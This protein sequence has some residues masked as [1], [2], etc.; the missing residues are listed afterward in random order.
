MI[1][2]TDKAKSLLN[3]GRI[4]ES[5]ALIRKRLIADRNP[6]ALDSLNQI[7]RNYGFLLHY[8]SEGKEDAG[9]DRMLSDIR[10]QLYTIIRAIEYNL[11]IKESPKLYFSQARTIKYSGMNFSNSFSEYIA[12]DSATLLLDSE[13]EEMR[14]AYEEK[15]R[16]LKDLFSIVWTLPIGDT[17]TLRE[18]VDA[19]C[20]PDIAEDFSALMISALTINLLMAYDRHKLMALVDIYLRSNSDTLKARLLTGILLI[21]NQYAQRVENDYE[22]QIR[23]ETMSETTMFA[24][25][26]RDVFFALVKARG[27]LNLSRRIEQE[28]LPEITKIG[29]DLINKLKDKDGNLNISNLEENPEWEKIMN[30]KVE[31]KL[32]K[33][34]D[35]QTSGGDIMIS[36]FAQLN[37]KFHRFNDIDVWFRP[38]SQ[39]EARSINI[40]DRLTEIWSKLAGVAT[41]CDP[42]KFVFAM[43]I[44]RLPESVRE[45]MVTAFEAQQEQMDEEIKSL[46][47]HSS[48][49]EFET[50]S[51]NYARVLFR[52][53]NF[54]RLKKEFPN[55]FEQRIDI[56]NIPFLGKYFDKSEIAGELADFF[57]KQEFYADAIDYIDI[58]SI[59]DILNRPIYLQKIGYC[60]E[61]LGKKS[62]ALK[63]YSE[64]INLGDDSAWTLRKIFKLGKETGEIESAFKAISQLL[65]M[66]TDN[67]QYLK[68]YLNF[69]VDNFEQLRPNLSQ[70]FSRAEYLLADDENIMRL[71]ARYDF[72]RGDY[73][74]AKEYFDAKYVDV[75]MYL[76]GKALTDA[77]KPAESDSKIEDNGNSDKSEISEV[78]DIL[79]NFSNTDNK[80]EEKNM[81]E[82]TLILAAINILTG[83]SYDAIRQIATVR[84]LT[85]SGISVD[86]LAQR[87]RMLINQSLKPKMAVNTLDKDEEKRLENLVNLHIDAAFKLSNN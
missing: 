78:S 83:N 38:F 74:A 3:S 9:R 48:M 40:S 67:S 85:K 68:E 76:A 44:S 57:F 22:M 16:R 25:K 59:I 84:L 49:P 71:K 27:G 87:L 60:L 86:Y 26:V 14:E 47:L 58:Q 4:S 69:G 82:D 54:F 10:E 77:V 43:N 13:S 53:F 1:S 52:F 17:D 55:P 37:G 72:L 34:N 66:E 31:K 7:E 15:N 75:Q 19:I 73:T 63:K 5:I 35:L 28:I 24:D 39:W 42:D 11:E 21:L 79:I 62:E 2:L 29:P 33:L 20:N 46:M 32:R 23:I 51:W 36:M 18:I 70:A 12:A 61:K 80:L 50:E 41:M 6:G 8:L 64:S 45:N 65:K 56:F 30:D 81:A